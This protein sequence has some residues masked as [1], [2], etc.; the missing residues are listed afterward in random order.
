MRR[1]C[2]SRSSHFLL[3]AVQEVHKAL[4]E[5]LQDTAER[6][7]QNKSLLLVGPHR[8][9]KLLVCHS[10]S[11]LGSAINPADIESAPED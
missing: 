5:A 2:R 8:C 11:R 6:P 10:D 4:M 9:G 7:G 1:F 3:H